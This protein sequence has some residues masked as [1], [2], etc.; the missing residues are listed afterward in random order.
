MA[1]FL[2]QPRRPGREAEERPV[3]PLFPGSLPGS[4]LCAVDWPEALH[5]ALRPSRCGWPTWSQDP[6][7]ALKGTPQAGQGTWYSCG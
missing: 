1:V 6:W 2:C 5:K 3:G 4:H 7:P